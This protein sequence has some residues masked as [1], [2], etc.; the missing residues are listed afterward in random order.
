MSASMW[1]L[2]IGL[3]LPFVVQGLKKYATYFAAN[4][5]ATRFLVVGVA[6]VAVVAT[7]LGTTG[8]VDVETTLKALAAALGS[9]EWSY[10][11]AVKTLGDWQAKRK[12]S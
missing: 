9:A 11:W 12:A 7:Q 8:A 1:A 6:L 3:A 4:Q 5:W 2:I 10:Q